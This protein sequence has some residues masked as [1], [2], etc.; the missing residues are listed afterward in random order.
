MSMIVAEPARYAG[1]AS[2]GIDE[3]HHIVSTKNRWSRVVLA[4]SGLVS[5]RWCEL[6][7][8]IAWDADEAAVAA[9]DFALIGIDPRAPDGSSLD[10][11]L[12]LTFEE[13][14]G[15]TLM[16]LTQS[17][18]PTAELR[19]EHGRGAPNA[20]DRLERAIRAGPSHYMNRQD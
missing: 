17:G 13:R 7:F 18:F 11:A 14:D 19:D 12:E 10:F 8:G 2:A 5:E 4:Y 16:T 15:G 3:D 1:G 9:P 20:V 6:S